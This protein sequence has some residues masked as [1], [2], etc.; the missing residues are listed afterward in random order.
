MVLVGLL[1]AVA[2]TLIRYEPL[3][4]GMP[5]SVGLALVAGVIALWG[6]LWLDWVRITTT[7][8]L[9][10]GARGGILDLDDTAGRMT[11]IGFIIATFALGASVLRPG[12][13]RRGAGI[14]LG[15]LMAFEGARRLT[16]SA[17][18]LFPPLAAGRASGGRSPSSR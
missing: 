2:V 9:G 17:A 7:S 18:D 14:A 10:D 11:W 15:V 12:K 8:G 1:V 3:E 6:T 4:E 5:S 16:V 13:A